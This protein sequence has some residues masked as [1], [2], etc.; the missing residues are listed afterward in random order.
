MDF[1]YLSVTESFGV[2]EL[3]EV[4]LLGLALLPMRMKEGSGCRGKYLPALDLAK[5]SSVI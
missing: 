4:S 1:T 3:F 5:A 2:V